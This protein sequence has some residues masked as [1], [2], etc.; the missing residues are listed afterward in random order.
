M[1]AFK[2]DRHRRLFDAVVSELPAL[3]YDG[4]LVILDYE[5]TDW[6][7][8]GD[9]RRTVPVAAFGQLPTTYQTACIA[10]VIPNGKA[11]ADL[12]SDF[13]ALG[14]F[15][16]FEVREDAVAAWRVGKELSADDERRVILPG[17]IRGTFA[18]Y[19]SEW[20]AES[21]LRGKNI[22]LD[23]GDERQLDFFDLGLIPALEGQIRE[24][25]DRMLNDVL[26]E[27]LR[28][29]GKQWE[30]LSL[31]EAQG[32]FRLVF[33]FLA[34]KV[35]HDRGFGEFAALSGSSDPSEVLNR[36]KSYYGQSEPVLDNRAVWD[37]VFPILW[38]R[39]KFQNLSVEVLAYIYEHTLVTKPLRKKLGIHGTP[40]SIA[41]YIVRS[42]PIEKLDERERFFLEPCSGHGIFLV[43]A[44]QRLRSVLRTPLSPEERHRYFVEMLE[45]YEVDSFALEVGWLC[46]M[47]ADF[48]NSNGWRLRL[49]DVFLSSDFRRSLQDARV[50][51][52]NPP[53]E[54]FSRSE[55]VRYA[56]L[57]S[58]L[59][60]VE[61]L[62]RVLDALHPE[63]M[64]GFVLPS[65]LLRGAEYR[66]VRRRLAERFGHIE[67][68]ELPESNVFYIS[69]HRSVL[70]IAHEPSPG[71]GVASITYKVLEKTD[72]E[73]SL[74]GFAVTREDHGEKTYEEAAASLA[75]PPLVE[76]WKYLE[77]L[78]RL[79]SL[80][81]IHRG[82]EWQYTVPEDD[83]RSD[84]PRSG[85]K[86]GYWSAEEADLMAYQ[87]PRSVYLYVREGSLRRGM[88]YNWSHKKVLVNRIRRSRKGWRYVAFVDYEGLY[89]TQNFHGV[90]PKDPD[91][92]IEYI[93]AILNNPLAAAFVA[94]HATGM[95]NNKNIL[96]QIPV[97]QNSEDE[98]EAVTML[99][100]KYLT[101][102]AEPHG[103]RLFGPGEARDALL[104]IDAIIL[105]GYGLPESLQLKALSYLRHADR[106]VAV[107]FKVSALE[108]RL[109]AG[110]P[111]RIE[112]PV[113]AWDS[114]NDRRAFLIDKE[115]TEGLGQEEQRELKQLQD[116][117]DSY[118][119]RFEPLPL[120]DLSWLDER[121]RQLKLEA[122]Q[123]GR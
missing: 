30:S 76:V 56:P 20:S 89:C 99:V 35:L 123:R 107:D 39:L 26:A 66:N 81:N 4:N 48:P 82:I 37:A 84:T 119:D 3:G 9:L 2:S 42:L 103:P 78:E 64:L 33:R 100:R 13:R 21:I 54:S 69:E 38:S 116:A 79:K 113:E 18:R 77:P 5:F 60:P 31:A 70:L 96:D 17:D 23:L 41:R 25:L 104:E 87:P 115:L 32:L 108:A 85:Y 80:A 8:P 98:R 59:K 49:G 52:C 11:G 102:L 58:D 97:P 75:I 83:R 40:S 74:V 110:A 67:V 95:E 88:N 121:V 92:T 118:L 61:L 28:V 71:T 47:L 12:I 111:H 105:N 43:A 65:T 68:V 109:S 55:K 57:R 93:A 27:A 7:Q 36:V 45:G 73:P 106:P 22:G 120:E 62:E 101:D 1:A 53:Y 112:N 122:E 14:A 19:S 86:K 63:G 94:C 46:L 50:I 117:A 44:L 24:K 91:T 6:F 15:V 114:Y 16:A 10:V 72:R 51:V 29:Y 34:A 90:W